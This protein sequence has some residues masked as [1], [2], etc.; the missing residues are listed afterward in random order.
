AAAGPGHWDAA[1][2]ERGWILRD[3]DRWRL[4]YTGYDGTRA[5]AK[6]L[7]L[8]VSNDGL[9][10]ERHPENPVHDAGWVEDVMIVPHDGRLYMFAEG[11]GDRAQLLVSADG[12]RWERA[13][14]LD[15]RQANGEPI[16]PGPYGTPTALREG[17][18]WHLFYERGD[19]AVW[20]ATSTDLKVWTNVS[21][22][23]VLRP[24]P[25]AYDASRI[26]LNQ[27]VRHGGRYYALYHGTDD[28]D[29]PALWTSNLAVSDDLRTWTKHPG[30]PLF[31]KQAN[32]SSNMLVPTAD[33]RFR[34]YT[35]HGRVEAF[36]PMD[37]E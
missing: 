30:N 36:L 10:W 2:R 28:R 25:D 19:R 33:G 29:S 1:I 31:P 20:L 27:I 26:A 5:G 6:K 8:A 32:R 14:P 18:V 13:G 37:G 15:V 12:V 23:P 7:G 11:E 4:W 24:G 9:R 3:G 22:E 35:M 17:G 21:D 16:P 34:L